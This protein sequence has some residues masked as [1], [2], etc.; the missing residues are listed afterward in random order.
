MSP[1]LGFIGVGVMGSGM[2]KNLAQKSG[3]VVMAA[4]HSR[5]N[6]QQVEQYGVRP[7]STGDIARDAEIV[8][9]SLPSINEVVS[10][11]LGPDGLFAQA[12]ALKIIVDMSTSDVTRTRALAAK[13]KEHGLTFLDA[14]VARS[15]EAA[16]NG[17]LL[18]T[19]GG[20]TADVERVRPY[21]EHMGSDVV[22]CG[23]TGTGQIAKIM[24]NMVLLS[25]VNALAEAFAIAEGAGMRKDLLAHTLSLG[26]ADSFALALTGEKYLAQDCFPEKMFSASY[27]LKD[28]NL[29]LNLAADAAL[30]TNI[31]R[32]T[33][34]NLS[35]AVDQGLG[36]AYYPV[37]YRLIRD[38]AAQ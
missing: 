32:H 2:C 6:L 20:D 21:L 23:D 5:D 30:T 24:N 38:S 15:R 36:D 7:C 22:H 12:G 4:D 35:Q 3:H 25:T 31:A 10:V 37:V 17:T 26:S 1:V 16:N 8:F 18:I 34:A 11:C 13:A 27:A 9:L 19:V 33:A 29:A 28:M 14:P